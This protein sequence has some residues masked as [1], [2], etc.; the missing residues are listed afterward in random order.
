M[1]LGYA[2]Q[3]PECLGTLPAVGDLVPKWMHSVIHE[4]T[5]CSEWE[6]A[7]RA[8]ELALQCSRSTFCPPKSS[9][10]ICRKRVGSASV[11]FNPCVEVLLG[12]E[13]SFAMFSASVH[14][15]VLQSTAKPWSD[16]R[17]P[18][19]SV[20]DLGEF[21]YS[22]DV[23]VDVPQLFANFLGSA[24]DCPISYDD[25]AICRDPPSLRKAVLI[26]DSPCTMTPDQPCL[27]QP[28]TDQ[29]RVASLS[30]TN[31]PQIEETYANG[32]V[33]PDCGLSTSRPV[34]PRFN[35]VLSPGVCDK[36]SNLVAQCSHISLDQFCN[37]FLNQSC[38][39][40]VSFITPP[41]WQCPADGQ[42]SPSQATPR[43]SHGSE[44]AGSHVPRP[45]SPIR[46]P[47]FAQQMMVNLPMEFLTNPRRIV[48]G[49]V[50]RSWYLH[51]ANI[52]QSLQARQVMLTGP[53]HFWRAQILHTWTDFIIPGED[54]TLDLV[55]PAPPRNWHE[56]SIV[57]DLILAQGLYT[58][59]F[60]G[61]VSVSPTIT[62]P[63][64]R[65]YAIA[66]SFASVISGQDIV[67]DSEVQPLCN[68]FDCLI[69]HAQQQIY[70]DFN[71]VHH[72][73]HGDSCVI[74][75]SRRPTPVAASTAVAVDVA[76]PS[77]EPAAMPDHNMDSDADV[78]QNERT[79]Q[80]SDI[81]PDIGGSDDAR[82]RVTL[83][84][85]DRPHV[86]AWIRWKRF[87][88]LLTDVLEIT[89]ISPSDLVAIHPMLVKPIGESVYEF[90]VIVQHLGDI[91]PG[92]D[93]SLILLDTVFHQHGPITQ[94]VAAP[95]VDRK[96]VKNP[97]RVTRSG[98]LHFARVANYCEMVHHACLVSINHV[99]WPLQHHAP[100]VLLHGSFGRIQIPPMQT[101][102]TET[103]RA[104]SLIEDVS[105]STAPSF[106]AVYPTL[107]HHAQ[108]NERFSH[109]GP[110]P[111]PHA[112]HDCFAA[113]VA[114]EPRQCHN[115][116]DQTVSA[117][118]FEVSIPAQAAPVMPNVPGWSDFQHEL[119][120]Q[121]AEL[122]FTEIPEEGPVLFVTTWFVHHDRSPVCVLGRLV[123]L[124][125]RP[126]EWLPLLCAPWVH[127]LQPF[128]DLEFRLVR[129]TPV[130]DIP[131]MHMIH[132]IL[133][134]GLQQSR[135]TA[136]FSA[137][138]QGLHGDVTHRRA[139]SIPTELS[140][141]LIAR[142]L[143]IQLLCRARRCVAWSGRLQFHRSRLERVFNGIGVCFTVNAFRNRFAHVD[144]DG[145]PLHGVASS[146]QIEPRMSFREEDA[147]LFPQPPSAGSSDDVLSE[148]A[149]S[150]LVPELTVIWQ[151]YLMTALNRPFRFYVETW[152]CDHDRFPRTNRGREV[153]LSPD[154]DT[155]RN[156]LLDKW[157]DLIDPAAE[158]AIY[159]VSPAPFGGPPEVLAHVILAQH[160]HRGFVSALVTTLTSGDDPWD[161]PRVALKLPS[162]VDK[163]LLIQESGLFMF[164]PPF[165]PSSRCTALYGDQPVLQ[166]AL[167]NARS[168][169]S[170]LCTVEPPA[171]VIG[172]RNE[173]FRPD[174]DVQRLFAMLGSTLVRL[175]SQVLQKSE[176]R[177]QLE[178]DHERLFD[179]C[180][181]LMD[182]IQQGLQS[183]VLQ[184]DVSSLCH[185]D[186]SKAGCL[187]LC[188]RVGPPFV[189]PIDASC[190]AVPVL[191]S[192]VLTS[193]VTMH[194][195]HSQTD[196]S[197]P[198]VVQVWYVDQYRSPQCTQG[199]YVTLQSSVEH[200]PRVLTLPWAHE[201]WPHEPLRA[202]VIQPVHDAAFSVVK[203]HILLSQ[204][205]QESWQSVLLT[206]HAGS[207]LQPDLRAI[208]LPH[209]CTQEALDS[210]L[211]QVFDSPSFDAT[212]KFDAYCNGTPW[213]GLAI[214]PPGRA[215]CLE[216]LPL[217]REGSWIGLQDNEFA[218]MLHSKLAQASRTHVGNDSLEASAVPSPVQ[219]PCPGH[220]VLISLD[221]VVPLHRTS[222]DQPFIEHL[223]TLEWAQSTDWCRQVCESLECQLHAIPKDLPLDAS[224]QQAIFQAMDSTIG[225][226]Q[227]LELY[228]DGAT[229]A[230]AA[231]W[232]VVAVVY[233]GDFPRLLGTFAGP[234]VLGP[235][236]PHWLGAQSIDNIAAELHALAAAL[237]LT[238]Q[239]QFPCP[240]IIRPDLSLSRLIA[241]ELV[242]TVS[243]PILAKMCRVLASWV[244]PT[245][246]YQEVRGHT[247]N[248]WNELADS[249]AKYALQNP[250][251][252]P[253]VS[254]GSL[255]QLVPL[256]HDLDWSWTQNMPPA[257]KHCF[258]NSVDN[259]VW[260]FSPS[261][262]KVQ[263]PV[264]PKPV[265]SKPLSFSCKAASI[266][267]LALDKV[268]SHS[269][270][271]R[272]TGARTLRLDHQLHN[273]QFHMAGLQET[274]TIAGQFR[275][276]HYLI[277]ASGG[278]GQ[279]AARFG[280]ELWLHRHL[281][282]LTHHDGSQVS[283]SDCACVVLHAD[284][285]R[286]FVKI[287]HP[288][289]QLTAV[290]LHAP[291]LGK[292][293]GDATAPIDV[294]KQ[295]WAETSSIWHATISGE[296]VC[297]FVDANATL[298]S[299][300]T[301]YFQ[302]HHADPTTAQSLVFEDFLIGHA[303]FAP[304]TFSALHHGP[305]YTWTHSSGR[306]MRLDYVL[307]NQALFAMVDKS[308]TWTSYDG[309][310]T[311]E[312]HIPACV[313]LSGWISGDV[314]SSKPHWDDLAL[315]DPARCREFQAALATLPIP[316]WEVST[317]SHC[318]LF[319]SQYL[320]LAKQFFTKKAGTRRRPTL[321][322]ESL[323]AIAF[324]R[325]VL[326]C[327]R[328]W[329]LMTDDTFK[330]ELKPI[331]I[332]VRK[333]VSRDLRNFYDQILVQLQEAGHLSDHK[334]MF[335]MLARVGGRKHKMKLPA[336]PLPMLRAPNGQFVQSFAQQ[337]KL[338]LDHFAKVE[339]GLHIHWQTLQRDDSRGLGLATDIQEA[340]TFPTDWDLQAAVAQL[341]R[342]K[343]PG[344]N[345]LTPC[346]LKA[347]GSTFT[348]QFVALTTK[349]VAHGKE[350]SVWKGGRLFPLH[351]GRGPPTEPDSYRAIYISDYTSKLYHRMLRQ[352]LEISWNRNME[353]LQ[354][355]GRK[356]MGTDIAHHMLQAHQF[357]CRQNKFASAV[358]FF[359]LRAA[360]YSVLRQAL[361]AAEID[362][363]ALI[364]ALSRFGVPQPVIDAWIQQAAQD[365]AIADA[366]PHLEKLIHDCMVN[367]FFT[368]DAVPGVCKT[369]R[370]TR[371]GDPLGDL[372]FN[373]IMR[374]VLRDTHAY[375]QE[376][377]NAEWIG[378]PCHC[379]SFARSD[380]ISSSAYFDVSFVDDAAIAVHASSLS[381][382]EQ[383]IKRA[384]EGFHQA[385]ALRGLDV[386]FD[387]G[388][389][390]VMW[391]VL[392]RG[393]KALKERLHDAGYRLCWKELGQAFCLRV[394]HSYK[395]LGSWMQTAG[396]HQREIQHRA[397]QALQS[398]GCLARSFY[399][400]PYVGIK[401]KS[402]AFQSLSMSRLLYN[403]HTWTGI[404]D[405]MLAHWQQ[406]LRKPIGLLAKPFLRGVAPVKVDTN[407]LF[408]IVQILPPVDQLHLA[409]L[410]YLKRLLSF[411]PQ[412]LWNFLHQT[413]DCQTGWLGACVTSFEWFLQFYQVP[414]APADS[415]DFDAWLSYIAL[416][417]CWKGRLK[418][419]AKGCLCFRQA[420]AEQN[421]WLK[422]FTSKFEEAGGVVPVK[423]QSAGVTWICDLCQKSFGSKRALATHSGRAHGYR[424][425]VKYYAIDTTCNACAKSYH[426]RK[427]LIEHLKD[428]AQCLQTLQAC[429]PPLSDEAV[430]ELDA[431]DHDT[432]LELRAQGW[433]ASKALTPMRKLYGP[434]LPPAGSVEAAQM[435][436]KWSV[437]NP[438]AGTAFDL[439]QGHAAGQADVSEP[440]VIFFAEDLPAFVM[441]S[442]CGMNNGDGRFSLFGL[443]RETAILHVRAQVF[444]H[445][446]SGYRRA[447]DLHDLLAHH[448]F[449]S[450]HQLFVLSI[451]MCLQ[452]ERGDL[453]SSSSL[454]W[455]LDRIRSGQICGAGGGPPCETYS[456]ARM[457]QDG[458]PPVRSEKWPEGIP[459]IPL[460]A[461]RQVMVGSRLMRFI[462]DVFL[463]LVLTG[464]CSFI[465]HP[466]Y[467]LW[468]QALAPASV[469]ASLPMR[470]LKTVA[471]VG[472][473]SFDQCIFGC[474]A[475]KPT[476]I[477]H[478]RL[479]TLRDTILRTGNMGRCM[480]LPASHEALFGRDATGS[481]KTARGKIYPRGLNQAIAL[482]VVDFVQGVF[483][484]TTSQHMPAEF[485]ELVVNSFVSEEIVQPDFYG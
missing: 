406:K 382:L 141:E 185:F 224:T 67:T 183:N 254:F 174:L 393:S 475:R 452:R 402:I 394:S 334:Q 12:M 401:A 240:V 251:L 133:E 44:A 27:F 274:R 445:F 353:F 388:K 255:H 57:F 77:P 120:I 358:V 28:A 480:H 2:V 411:C 26:P 447:G 52:L 87:A 89:N 158:V 267:V 372:L 256:S 370:G 22:V 469:W 166:D 318:E 17:V 369:T 306:R 24:S 176:L 217:S 314:V 462:L 333:L 123:R 313:A 232:S 389:T 307:L 229:S 236:H 142:L 94:T 292:A 36:F 138:F 15:D 293:T 88:H 214:D 173:A 468:A 139:Q 37:L 30:Q 54:L 326:D 283:F 203:A 355:G 38:S 196:C 342:G 312:D 98:I 403:A 260:Q 416:D 284:S 439:F 424:R 413:K 279:S 363:T 75:L 423:P 169:D 345:G 8:T 115:A 258:P 50:V 84:R 362:P 112:M 45:G 316:A 343:T 399:N 72:M 58:G 33:S 118:T 155:W 335:R 375:I 3:R 197:Q 418:K 286:L 216:V 257:L 371:P 164:C 467:P 147:T 456:A 81:T 367:T 91:A 457:L 100:K 127:L 315:L 425:M 265:Q 9:G 305:S 189:S 464:G 5:F 47:P 387:Q 241:Q 344:P 275:S 419:A 432:T 113:A 332:H 365:H 301:E 476:T 261:L 124:S 114:H 16:S 233:S 68:R 352:Q 276:E 192:D 82:R 42:P 172:S 150:R 90:S 167:R 404:T 182:E 435:Y 346:L 168:G 414:G 190:F 417:S 230:V 242:T 102:A 101:P 181:V 366:S 106:A 272:R 126:H 20:E 99:A 85:L 66:V 29:C 220:P 19:H 134:Q 110:A 191:K 149:Q 441:Q 299:T 368:L 317:G 212:C 61:L 210:V 237:A 412:G 14:S 277:F 238:L 271:G 218:A 378:T 59:R 391:D 146:S 374:L 228:V 69:F 472:I 105:D 177:S 479:P 397:S 434:C 294:V 204:H 327:G 348:K 264:A 35:D 461:W 63:S 32:I 79:L 117:P 429:F 373:L 51:H 1:T 290:V 478:L 132:V 136:L 266:N 360:F 281:P 65:M 273:A 187:P 209:P 297:G 361:I 298:A 34:E 40:S 282:F 83:Y 130:S 170:Y 303:L 323:D 116:D 395:H 440:R 428:A 92:S 76:D 263:P 324:K 119:N 131:G 160:Q 485:Q 108:A 349:T 449:E 300:N 199:K 427:R 331:E 165:I 337:Q 443:A 409:R 325:H 71:P 18:G 56:T 231:S 111:P 466:Q 269:E 129:P 321:S 347:G 194:A 206:V 152:F 86:S 482:A 39:E 446:F 407:D 448:V 188:R 410:R 159:V 390:E 431:Q 171:A 311:H 222:A 442:C 180:Q 471:A 341:H 227:L 320:Q 143:D 376:C 474:P 186:V 270:V 288:A 357:W 125:S 322:R 400:K 253:P 103:C 308:E 198:F 278:D 163:G 53:P 93:E 151:H 41:V 453:A 351:K 405:E 477:I 70:I 122:S 484:P 336:R 144:D 420:V 235:K 157:R 11:K 430:L 195:E 80:S 328:A 463:L 381:D 179:D 340:M 178:V 64:L 259:S 46:L 234:V 458:P 296:Y 153:L 436:A 304:S 280:C 302:S 78:A 473:T 223:S 377:T 74:F 140:Q 225:P 208:A 285:R 226:Y 384:V 438:S 21:D 383:L 200:W 31:S 392:G 289:I 135:M 215:F 250:D 162:V 145:Y 385:A 350:P 249:L 73:T 379:E 437:R 426:T 359:D 7:H 422:N 207:V 421:I 339:A 454:S 262:R 154:P 121:F 455:W 470:L 202:Q 49:F 193:L 148:H 4:P 252:F 396:S 364:A 380:E 55:Q 25:Q 43:E 415:H 97:A 109:G 156:T 444:V 459:N 244:P 483:D 309:T 465:E 450:G 460:R 184:R 354:V 248:A 243:N 239:A 96:V 13:D 60:S 6:A 161:P 310:F 245:T 175:T 221:A 408:A 246:S 338:W 398:W 319:E 451:D 247:G 104:V 330:A 295:W 213:N 137:I 201:F 433:Q 211:H 107:P 356:H 23:L 287:E 291:C 48:Q 386:N 10:R 128:E 62:E 268:D 481:F 219:V 329:G 95:V 205:V